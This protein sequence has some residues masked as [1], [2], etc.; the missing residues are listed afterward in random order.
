MNVDPDDPLIPTMHIRWQAAD[1]GTDTE[2]QGVILGWQ[3]AR[4]YFVMQQLW[5]TPDGTQGEWRPVPVV[6]EDAPPSYP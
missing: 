1:G 4:S 5:T 3:G 6:P 2:P